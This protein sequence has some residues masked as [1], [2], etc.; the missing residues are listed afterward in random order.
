MLHS[1]IF[2]LYV[3]KAKNNVREGRR[4]KKVPC[5]CN[6]IENRVS[7]KQRNKKTETKEN[8]ETGL[9]NKTGN[10]NNSE[11]KLNA[12]ETLNNVQKTGNKKIKKAISLLSIRFGQ[13]DLMIGCWMSQ[14][15]VKYSLSAEKQFSTNF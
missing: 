10:R 9:E 8:K 6:E 4:F 15:R 3:C 11:D 12:M 14:S 13:T 2:Y 1:S 7:Y 5:N